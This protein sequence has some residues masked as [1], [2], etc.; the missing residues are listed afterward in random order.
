MFGMLEP[1]RRCHLGGA[2]RGVAQDDMGLLHFSDQLLRSNR[3]ANTPAGSVE[4][5]ADGAY[6]DGVASNLRC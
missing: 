1:Y 2:S 6:R 5:F 3:I 4:R